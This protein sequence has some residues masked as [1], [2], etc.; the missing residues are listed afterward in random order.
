MRPR[1]PG[2]NRTTQ[3]R[4]VPSGHRRMSRRSQRAILQKGNPVKPTQTLTDDIRLKQG[5]NRELY[6]TLHQERLRREGRSGSSTDKPTDKDNGDQATGPKTAVTL[7]PAAQLR[8]S[9]APAATTGRK[10]K[11][12]KPAK[13]GPQADYEVSLG[14]ESDDSDMVTDSGENWHKRPLYPKSYPEA[15]KPRAK[16]LRGRSPPHRRRKVDKHDL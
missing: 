4:P 6:D 1:P 15:G 2:R 7:T 12:T 14:T 11:R 5:Q 8:T 13:E 9:S 16:R 10:K 3:A